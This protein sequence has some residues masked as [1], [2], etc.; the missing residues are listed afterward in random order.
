MKKVRQFL[1]SMLSEDS[2]VSHKRV[3]VFGTFVEFILIVVPANLLFGKHVDDNIL[4]VI[5]W[6]ILG[7]MGGSVIQAVGQAMAKAKGDAGTPDT[8]ITTTSTDTTVNTDTNT[9]NT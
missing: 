1:S 2:K 3:I 9:I 7:G 5:K 6:V 8:V 4:E